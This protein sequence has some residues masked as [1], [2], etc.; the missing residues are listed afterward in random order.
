MQERLQQARELLTRE[1]LNATE[2]LPEME[3]ALK[4]DKALQ[5]QQKPAHGVAKVPRVMIVPYIDDGLDDDEDEYR[6][7][8]DTGIHGR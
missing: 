2:V 7:Y 5:E 6:L 3:A 1:I 8:G 4:L